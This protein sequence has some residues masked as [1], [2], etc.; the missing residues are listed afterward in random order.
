MTGDLGP[1][2]SEGAL[3]RGLRAVERLGNRLPDPAILFVLFWFGTVLVS[4][5]LASVEFTAVDPRTQQPLRVKDLTTGAELVGM[6]SSLVKNFT[7]FQPLG[8]VLVALLGVGVAEHA[9]YLDAVLKRLLEFTPRRFL[10]PMVILVALV[11]HTAGDA[12][13]VL[14]IPLGAVIYH[15]AGRHPIAGIAATFAGVSGGFSANFVPSGIDPLLQ[16]FTE[17]AAKLVDP[18][19]TVNPLCNWFFMSAS[20]VM[21]VALGWWITDRL[22]EPRLG[23]VAVDGD[24]AEIPKFHAL[25]PRER[26]ALL[27][28][29]LSLGACL[30]GLVAAVLPASSPLRAPDGG[31]TSLS[32]PLMQSI[33]PLIFV[34]FLVPGVVFGVLSGKVRSHRDVIAGM[35][36]TMGTM[37]YYLVLAFFA[38]QFIAAFGSSNLGAL[39]ALQ[40]AELLKALALPGAVTILGVILLSGFVDLFIGSS[41]AKWALMSPIL[42]PMLMQVGLSPELVQA[43]YRIGDSVANIVTPLMQYFPLVVV[44]CRRWSRGTGVGNLVAWMLPYS[45]VFLIA[46][47]ALLLGFWALGVPLGLQSVYHYP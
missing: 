26:R 40:G 7:G 35:T 21:V 44:Y 46:W 38:A 9:G 10:T 36:K 28:A 22:L 23:H 11:S 25:D 20:C 4:G 24:P 15:A 31:L 17:Q 3:A 19:R 13:F 29:N 34:V 43:S 47:S 8:I 27:W 42:V 6:L 41:S 16:G 2:R 32:A 1:A 45:V 18:A 39:L 30:V 33:V 37:S 5:L 14:V 12:G